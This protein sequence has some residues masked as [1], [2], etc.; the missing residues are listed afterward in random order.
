MRTLLDAGSL[1]ASQTDSASR[2][3]CRSALRFSLVVVDSGEVSEIVDR[4][5]IAEERIESELAPLREELANATEPKQRKRLQRAIRRREEQI[6]RE[7]LGARA[8]W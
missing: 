6:R 1:L 8:H 7:V 4:T 2:H 5:P 3:N